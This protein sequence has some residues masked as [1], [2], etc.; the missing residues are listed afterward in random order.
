MR[1]SAN[2]RAVNALPVLKDGHP[3]ASIDVLNYNEIRAIQQS[4]D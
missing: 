3:V 4:L 2:V 1:E